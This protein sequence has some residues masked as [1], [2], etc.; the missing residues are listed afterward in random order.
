MLPDE[1]LAPGVITYKKAPA[2]SGARNLI[3][4]VEI[5]VCG[6]F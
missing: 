3:M 6:F 4:L 5:N 2:F 1:M